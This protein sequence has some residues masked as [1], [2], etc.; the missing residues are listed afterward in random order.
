MTH[1]HNTNDQYYMFLGVF[2]H[3]H[4]SLHGRRRHVRAGAMASEVRNGLRAHLV[5]S[6]S[7]PLWTPDE[8]GC[9]A[10][11]LYCDPFRNELAKWQV[12]VAGTGDAAPVPALQP[13]GRPFSHP[14]LR[15]QSGKGD[16]SC[17]FVELCSGNGSMVV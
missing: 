12:L 7:C 14:E 6:S 3:Q 10:M 5:A 13:E 9:D 8:R 11:R 2:H 16:A 4:G 15:Q 17:G 1:L